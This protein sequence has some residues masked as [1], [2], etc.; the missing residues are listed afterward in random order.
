MILVFITLVAKAAEVD[1]RT[2][3][4]NPA[5]KTL[6][7]FVNGSDQLPP[8]IMM[9][10]NDVLTISFD[11]LA[12]DRRYMRYSLMHCN[13]LWQPDRMLPTEYVEGF[14]EGFVEKYSYSQAT[15]VQYVHYEIEIPDPQMQIKLSGNYLLRVYDESDPETTL[16]QVRFSVAEPTMEARATVTSRT[17]VDT[18][19]SHQQ[20]TVAVDTRTLNMNNVMTDVII[21]VSQ[22]SRPDTETAL[23]TPTRIAGTVAWWEHT[24]A[25]IFPAGNEY[26][27]MEVIS[28]T[29][30][31]MGVESISYNDP[32]YH[33]QLHT[34]APRADRPYSFDSTQKGRFRIREYNSDSPEV[35]ADYVMVH[36]ALDIPPLRH[37]D[38]FI[39][40]DLG[41]RRY[42]PET[43]MVFNRAT[44]LYEAA[45]LLKQGAYNYQ[46]VTVPSGSL[47][48]D[49]AQIEGNFYQTANE[50]L[51]KVYYREPGARYDRL[52][53]VTSVTAGI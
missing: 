45:M 22:N 1:T 26:R 39:D 33:F 52:V 30:P 44:G 37:G 2:A 43:M 29:Y 23:N 48:G 25:L 19:R 36:F 42:S 11:E 16:L 15:L 3:I 10:S 50:Y 12:G 14:N 7:T 51:V 53:A 41:L 27:R 5:F 35:E 8:V 31:G 40:G 13:A 6:Q 4:F 17:D 28:T 47:K 34:D 18:N 32:L 24:P 46:Y 49:A 38:V 9:G 20:L 21:V